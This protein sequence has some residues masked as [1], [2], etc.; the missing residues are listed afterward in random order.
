MY[1]RVWTHTHTHT[2][3]RASRNVSVHRFWKVSGRVQRNRWGYGAD[4][5]ERST[6]SETVG[7]G[8]CLGL[9]LA[10]L[11]KNLR[12]RRVIKEPEGPLF[13]FFF[14]F[15]FLL[16]L[17]FSYRVLFPRVC[18]WWLRPGAASIEFYMRISFFTCPASNYSHLITRPRVTQ[19]LPASMIPLPPRRDICQADL[20]TIN[21][22]NYLQIKKSMRFYFTL[23]LSEIIRG[24]FPFAVTIASSR[25]ATARRRA[26]IIAR[27]AKS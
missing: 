17:F 14:F 5:C 10:Y 11:R 4:D 6:V 21:R 12:P 15:F 2:H 16:L 20:S 8:V 18:C 27:D 25:V 22:Q 9:R 3:T 26:T 1:T 19:R 23:S 24:N 7:G 13:F